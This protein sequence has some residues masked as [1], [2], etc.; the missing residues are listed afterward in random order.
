MTAGPDLTPLQQEVERAAAEAAAA[1]ERAVSVA[2][3]AAAS[4]SGADSASED[5][6]A[7]LTGRKPKKRKT[8]RD[9]EA[10][11][12]L[13]VFKKLGEAKAYAFGRA[14]KWADDDIKRVLYPPPPPPPKPAEGGGSGG[15]G[16]SPPPPS[17]GDDSPGWKPVKDPIKPLPKDC[18]VTPLGCGEEH[19]HY[20]DPLNQL[21]SLT[22]KGHDAAGLRGLFK[23]RIDVLWS[24]WPKF[25]ASSGNQSGFQADRAS[26]SLMHACSKR[27]LFD[28]EDAVRGVGAWLG[29]DGG[30]ILHNGDSLTVGGRIR[31]PGEYGPHIYPGY[32]AAPRPAKSAAGAPA[33]FEALLALLDTWNWFTPGEG[34]LDD[35]IAQQTIGGHW[36]QAYVLFG[37]LGVAIAG[38]ALEYRPPL[39]ITGERN[40]GKSALFRLMK[41]IIGTLIEGEDTSPAYIRGM[42]GHS[43][44][45]VLLDEAENDPASR[46]NQDMIV[47]ARI[48]FSGGKSGRSSADHKLV[49]SVMRSAFCF[50]SIII[51][52]MGGQDFSR[53]CILDLAPIAKGSLK[54]DPKRNAETGALMR[55]VIVERWASWPRRLD[56]WRESLSDKGH[57][58]RGCDAFGNLLAMADLMLSAEPASEAARADICAMFPP[59]ARETSSNAQDMLALLN[60]KAVVCFKAKERRTIGRLLETAT[61]VDDKLPEGADSPSGCEE[62]LQSWGIYL[63]QDD[64]CRSPEGG[65]GFRVILPNR[66]DELRRL[67]E[68]SQWRTTPGATGGWA[69][70]MKRLPGAK[71]ESSNKIGG[72]G[73]SVPAKVFLLRE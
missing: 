56:L 49:Q 3:A 22:P 13:R 7:A 4:K 46:R 18:P 6:P 43:T 10:A 15:G 2:I 61:V 45:P 8:E 39:W 51:P 16:S 34:A 29:D 53:F 27:G 28:A 70:A 21:R 52:P 65:G 9:E 38:G 1:A 14:M 33:A 66:H 20:L 60:S 69:Q 48:A 23:H 26:E 58:S 12:I 37:W 71:P 50:S 73:W 44:R 68:G 11:E 30:I 17:E 67:F 5:A 32:P 62:E 42:L 36:R 72:R 41:Q 25:N 19:F 57:D 64:S 55:R 40:S 63:R 54:L 24:H 35:G 47:V 59:E 31:P